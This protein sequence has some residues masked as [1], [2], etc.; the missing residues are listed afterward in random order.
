[1]DQQDRRIPAHVAIIMDGNGRW[2]ER[3]GKARHQGHRAGANAVRAI[4]EE[5]AALGIK[6]LTLFAFSSENWQRP[7]EEV[8]FLMELFLRALEQEM[9]TL[10]KRDIRFR[11]IGDRQ[12]LPAKL[13]E[14]IVD[15]EQRSL[16]NKGL[17]VQLAVSYGGRWDILQA[18][19]ALA[20]EVAAGQLKPSDINEERFACALSFADLPEVDL[21]IRTGGEIRISNFLLWQAAYAEFYF[22]DVLWPDFDR[23]ALYA[24]LDDYAGR[25]RRFGRVAE[26]GDP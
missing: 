21:F 2:A 22:T 26:H 24:A 13:V 12:Q 4:I 11:V 16:H 17:V 6:V 3:Q 8:S 23:A 18:A 9:Q 15:A 7:A 5:S 10:A 1:M 14:K 19:R 25:Q 20:A